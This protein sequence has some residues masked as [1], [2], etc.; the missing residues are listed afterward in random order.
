M[1]VVVVNC[2][3]AVDA[4]ATIPSLA[5]MVAAKT[6]LLPPP[7]TVASINNDCYCRHRW[8]PLLLPHS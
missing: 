1:A 7:S 2:A 4:I 5:L 8:P 6:P 3:A